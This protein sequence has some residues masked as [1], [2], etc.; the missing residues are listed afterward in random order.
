MGQIEGASASDEW[1]AGTRAPP[2]GGSVPLLSALLS[3]GTAFMTSDTLV[4]IS[5]FYL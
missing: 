1:C 2:A 3:L 5:S 4:E